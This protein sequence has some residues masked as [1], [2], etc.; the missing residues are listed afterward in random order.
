[1]KRMIDQRLI[2]ELNQIGDGEQLFCYLCLVGRA[3]NLAQN[4]EMTQ[5]SLEL[6]DKIEDMLKCGKSEKNFVM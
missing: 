2:D 1:M 6:L 5:Q 4:P 3:D